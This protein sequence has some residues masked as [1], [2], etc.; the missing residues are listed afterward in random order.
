M[1]RQSKSKT[2]AN[3][4]SMLDE[5]QDLSG[6][7]YHSRQV[8]DWLSNTKKAI[9][10]AFDDKSKVSQFLKETIRMRSFTGTEVE[11]QIEY[12]VALNGAKKF[13]QSL[14][15][16][17]DRFWEDD[18]PAQVPMTAKASIEPNDKDVFVVHGRNQEVLKSVMVF[19][20]NLGLNPIILSEQPGKGRSII[21]KFEDHAQVKYAIALL[22]PDDKAVL[23]KSTGKKKLRARQ[24]VIFE[25][26]FFV[27]SLGRERLAALRLGE[28]EIPSDYV[29][30][31]YIKLDER[32]WKRKLY[33]ELR[34]AGFSIDVEES[35]LDEC[36]GF[37][38]DTSTQS[39]DIVHEVPQEGVRDWRNIVHMVVEAYY[40]R[41]GEKEF[42]TASVLD[43]LPGEYL[44]CIEHLPQEGNPKDIDGNELPGVQ[45]YRIVLDGIKANP[46][47]D[48]LEMRD[49]DELIHWRLVN[50]D[51]SVWETKKPM[52]FA[53]QRI[54]NRK[55][56]IT[57]SIAE[58]HVLFLDAV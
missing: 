48:L 19:L 57:F 34:E 45:Y 37:T 21:K 53:I 49:D 5:L 55:S 27:G 38:T 50:E 40:R 54:R 17:V 30:V 44:S 13:L 51:R 24:N 56:K 58:M 33:K 23:N 15:D 52:R 25:M 28:V 9:Q 31:E 41:A 3:L 11:R 22:T 8:S 29:G 16:E 2:K 12:M 14:L 18:M 4:Q 39:D 10:Y 7:R 20:K 47:A 1:Q 26:G 6:V 35:V 32:T 46:T 36:K 43:R 42:S